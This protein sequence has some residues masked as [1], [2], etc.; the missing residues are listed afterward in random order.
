MDGR[1]GKEGS[2]ME[3]WSRLGIGER[4]REKEVNWGM[5]TTE[6]EEGCVCGGGG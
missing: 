6:G 4:E 1:G 2:G 3:K 5:K